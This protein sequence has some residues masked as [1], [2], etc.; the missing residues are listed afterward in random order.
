MLDEVHV[1]AADHFVNGALR[2]SVVCGLSGSLVREDERLGRLR[3]AVGE[4]IFRH[5]E[6]RGVRYEVR[7]VA[8]DHC[9][10]RA[11]PRSP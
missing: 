9:P 6:T 11:P 3:E 8:L 1:A 2:A 5:H 7:A 10:P 4:V